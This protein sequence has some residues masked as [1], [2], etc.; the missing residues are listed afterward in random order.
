MVE[1]LDDE[2]VSYES[3]GYGECVIN[4]RESDML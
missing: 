2:K 4:I 3:Y 1:V